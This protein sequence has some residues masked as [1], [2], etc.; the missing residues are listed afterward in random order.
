MRGEG[1]I[2][3]YVSVLAFVLLVRKDVVDVCAHGGVVADVEAGILRPQ[4]DNAEVVE[5][6]CIKVVLGSLGR[7]LVI[8]IRVFGILEGGILG[9]YSAGGRCAQNPG[10]ILGGRLVRDG[11]VAVYGVVV[12]AVLFLGLLCE[13]LSLLLAFWF[14]LRFVSRETA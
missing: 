3:A 9:P 13:N 6:S 4:N 14:S 11:G 7:E 10:K 8:L 2:T 1:E 5:C 12:T